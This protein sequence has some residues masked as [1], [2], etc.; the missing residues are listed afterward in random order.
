MSIPVQFNMWKSEHNFAL[1]NYPHSVMIL[2]SVIMVTINVTLIKCVTMCSD[3]S[4]SAITFITHK[5]L[6]FYDPRSSSHN[7]VFKTN[8]S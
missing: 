1:T 7:S 6:F 8:K 4:F 5:S 3:Y 2:T